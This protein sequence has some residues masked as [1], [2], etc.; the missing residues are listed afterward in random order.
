MGSSLSKSKSKK[1]KNRQSTS[2]AT[3]S[4]SKKTSFLTPRRH[5]VAEASVPQNPAQ[6]GEG[7]NTVYRNLQDSHDSYRQLNTNN[8]NNTDSSARDSGNNSAPQQTSISQPRISISTGRPSFSLLR[9][10]KSSQQQ[11]EDDIVVQRNQQQQRP[12]QILHISAPIIEPNATTSSSNYSRDFTYESISME[13]PTPSRFHHP[14]QSLESSRYH[15]QQSINQYVEPPRMKSGAYKAPVPLLPHSAQTASPSPPSHLSPP[16]RASLDSPS[17]PSPP[18]SASSPIQEPQRLWRESLRN[19]AAAEGRNNDS[20]LARSNSNNSSG[21]FSSS[22]KGISRKTKPT[23]GSTFVSSTLSSSSSN[24]SQTSLGLIRQGSRRNNTVHPEGSAQFRLLNQRSFS[25]HQQELDENASTISLPGSRHMGREGYLEAGEDDVSVNVSEMSLAG[26]PVASGAASGSGSP[27]P[28]GI[29]PRLSAS[30]FIQRSS[31]SGKVSGTGEPGF[32][33]PFST[34]SLSAIRNRTFNNRTA[35]SSARESISSI[36]T[37]NY[38]WMDDQAEGSGIQDM[39]NRDSVMMLFNNPA[40]ASDAGSQHSGSLKPD[41]L[42]QQ[43]LEQET[44]Q[45]A[46][47]KYFFKGNYHAPLNTQ[48]LGSVLDVGC[49]A[50]VWM[51]DMALEFPMTEVHGI[52][53]VVPPRRRRHRADVSQSSNQHS[54]TSSTHSGNRTPEQH[55]SSYNS[56]NA[57]SDPSINAKRGVFMPSLFTDSLPSN[58]FFHKADVTQ[59]LPFPDNTFDYCHVRLVLWSYPL[60]CFPELLHELIRV[61]KKD[62]WIEFVDMDPCIKKATEPGTHINEWIKTGLI[63]SN[64][65]PDLV[66][67]LPRFIK[68]FCDATISL[69]SPDPV[70]PIAGAESVA[71]HTEPFGLSHMKATKISLPFGPWGGKVGE[72]WQQSF[73]T[74]LKELEPVMVEATLSGL[75]MDQYHR[76]YLQEMQQLTDTNR[77]RINESDQSTCTRMAWSRLI[78]Q[79]VQDATA[80]PSYSVPP[81]KEMRSYTNFYVVYAQK[82]DLMELKQ[83]LLLQQLEQHILSPNPNIASTSTFSL[84]S[85]ATFGS[86]TPRERSQPQKIQSVGDTNGNPLVQNRRLASTLRE[87]SSSSNLHQKYVSSGSLTADIPNDMVQN[88]NNSNGTISVLTQDALETFNR[89][90]NCQQEQQ[91]P[92]SSSSSALS[93]SSGAAPPTPTSVAALSIR[94]NS[95]T[96]NRNNSVSGGGGSGAPVVGTPGSVSSCHSPRIAVSG[97]RPQ[98]SFQNLGS[99]QHQAQHSNMVENGTRKGPFEADYFSQVPYP[100]DYHHQQ[101]NYHHQQHLD[102]IKRKPNQVSKIA[103]PA[104]ASAGLDVGAAVP[105]KMRTQADEYYNN[106]PIINRDDDEQQLASPFYAD[107]EA[108][109]VPEDSRELSSE[110]KQDQV[111]E[112]DHQVAVDKLE[113]S[114]SDEKEDDEGGDILIVLQDVD[115]ENEEEIQKNSHTPEGMVGVVPEYQVAVSPKVDLV[116]IESFSAEVEHMGTTDGEPHGKGNQNTIDIINGVSLGD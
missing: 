20:P 10:R 44:Q 106:N 32:M 95:R 64:M 111:V 37:A 91:A 18:L 101:Y 36:S 68:Q 7:S 103:S 49:G 15:Q 5:S 16:P 80:T 12:P 50:G 41:Q 86:T 43:R 113:V 39:M 109:T 62:G 30:N 93:P 11:R 97:L 6:W 81:I 57:S 71:L 22:G 17:Y 114:A 105:A 108:S 63:H 1:K 14:R 98:G 13:Q 60:N 8:N 88:N 2:S 61:T 21:S 84:V 42:A 46:L 99:P 48:D 23:S 45:H 74:F 75:V 92:V 59:G 96:S 100:S 104:A 35:S 54:P 85:A 78:Q 77:T 34:T 115:D 110:P 112:T 116:P 67:T 51:K 38:Q 69:A 4:K 19:A 79:L 87:K 83:Q 25:Q 107:L 73:T 76:Q 3:N 56:S 29:S 89:N 52:D 53:L 90:N 94:S 65:D 102:N 55:P 47:L 58:C 40:T 82:V 27:S 28:M 31:P 72:L 9:G 26:S 33:D 24:A 70:Y 66:K